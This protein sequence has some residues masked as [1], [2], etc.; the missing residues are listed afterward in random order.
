MA[1]LIYM[2]LTNVIKLFDNEYSLCVIIQTYRSLQEVKTEISKE[3]SFVK[4]DGKIIFDTLFHVG[5]SEDR[6]I[7][8]EA[9]NGILEWSTSKCVYLDRENE[10]RKKVSETLRDN[11][12]ILDNSVLTNVQKRL[13]GKGIVI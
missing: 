10:I 11:I 4:I 8:V 1:R 13:I 7:E 5:S 2:N 3:I 6:F 12:S 9:N